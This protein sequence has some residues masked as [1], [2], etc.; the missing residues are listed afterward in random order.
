MR[1]EITIMKHLFTAALSATV[2]VYHCSAAWATTYYVS[3]RGDDACT[4]Q[5]AQSAKTP[6]KSIGKA[7]KQVVAGDVVVVA[8]GTY[9]ENVKVE[10]KHGDASKWIVFKAQA[11]TRPKIVGGDIGGGY[12]GA[13]NVSDSSYIEFRG[14]ELTAPNVTNSVGAGILRSHHVRVVDC[15]AHSNGQSGISSG[16]SDYLFVENNLVYNNCF[17]GIWHGSG[18]SL[19]Q[20]QKSDDA[21]GFHSIV[22]GNVSH[23]N[24]ETDAITT[25]HTDGNGIII[26]DFQNTQPQGNKINYASQTLVENNLCYNNGA[27]GIQVYLSDNVTVRNNTCYFNN[28]DSGAHSGGTWRGELNHSMSSNNTWENN[29]AVSNPA[30]NKENTAIFAGALKG[31]KSTGN[32]FHNNLTF[33]GIPGNASVKVDFGGDASSAVVISGANGNLLGVDPQFINPGAYDFRLRTA[34][35]AKGKGALLR[36]WGA[37]ERMAG[38][39][40]LPNRT[41]ATITKDRSKRKTTALHD[42]Q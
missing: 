9:A 32:I 29:I 10:N 7:V 5:Q 35:P 18:I 25:E 17:T 41:D 24:S 30:Y 14:F 19:Y 11:G 38:R 33:N 36:S 27:K 4:A 15:I 1:H 3:V 28:R 42:G 2:S 13:V 39:N 20:N 37:T 12:G 6:W 26:D 22:R 8:P 40:D 34:S 31:Y 21:P 23:S 16:Q